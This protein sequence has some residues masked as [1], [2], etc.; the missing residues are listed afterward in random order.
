MSNA[1][2]GRERDRGAAPPARACQCLLPACQQQQQQEEKKEQQPQQHQQQQQQ[3][4]QPS[5]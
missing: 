3:P 2:R 5:Q 4:S 1:R